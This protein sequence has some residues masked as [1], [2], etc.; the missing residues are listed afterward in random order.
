MPKSILKLIA[1]IAICQSAGLLGA[2]FTVSS[3]GNW[4]NLLNQPSFRPPNWIFGPTWA[5]LYTLMGI[6]LYWV[7]TKGTK[8]KK[9]GGTLGL[10][11]IHLVLNASWS[12]IFFGLHNILLS[13][14][15][16]VALWILIVMVII[17][18]YRIDKK[19]SLILLPYLAWVS[20]ATLLNYNI[21]LLNR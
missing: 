19:S 14:V 5:T 11:V 12:I 9:D 13:L 20:F 3:I 15:N 1:S 18:F 6:S 16:I 21:W 2:L 4:Y 8:K 7:W 17:G 10:F